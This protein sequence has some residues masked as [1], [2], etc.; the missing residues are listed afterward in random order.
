[1]IAQEKIFDAHSE[2]E[3]VAPNIGSALQPSTMGWLNAA[4]DVIVQTFKRPKMRTRITKVKGKPVKTTEPT[5]KIEY[6]LRTGPHE[7][8]FTKFRVPRAR[9]TELP[10]VITDPDFDK[11]LEAIRGE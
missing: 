6:C 3:L 7:A 9:S 8:Y 10:D 4:T 2:N 5:G 1:V 11:L